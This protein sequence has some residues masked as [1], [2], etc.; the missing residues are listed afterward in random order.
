MY[1]LSAPRC[2]DLRRYAPPLAPDRLRS[3]FR[4]HMG[5]CARPLIRLSRPFLL[6]PSILPGS[7]RTR[8]MT[9]ELRS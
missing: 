9:E 6:T 8:S 3:Y 7:L 1:Y 2:K 4:E 5:L